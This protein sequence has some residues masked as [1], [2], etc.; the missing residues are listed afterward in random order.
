MGES[1]KSEKTIR[2]YLLGRVLDETRLEG[3]EELLFTDEDFCSQVALA[4]DELINDYVFGRLGDDD[5]E[6]FRATLAG[7]SERRFKLELT[8]AL[9]EKA[10]AR[11][12]KSTKERPP[13]FSSLIL[14]FRQPV[15]A[16]AFAVLLLAVVA[17]TLYFS[18][19]GNPDAMAEL[20]SVYQMARPTETRISEF[21]YAPLS[22][23]RG[24]PTHADANRLRRIENNLIEATEKNSNAD[25]HHA[26]GV[27][28]LT[29]RRY[30]IAIKEFE[31]ALKLG[32]NSART[33]NDLGVA[34]FE[35]S[36]TVAKEKKL[37]EVARSLE[38][39]TKA[40]GLDGNL[41]EALFNKA[42]ALESLGSPREAK[43]SWMLYLNKDSSSPWADEARKNLAGLE[44]EQTLFKSE[45][46]VLADFLT[47]YRNHDYARAQKIHN[48]TK[49]LL[50]SSA[51]PM[52]LSRR[53]LLARQRGNETEATES[54]EALTHVGN[55]ERTLNGDSFFFELANFY[56]RVR[57]NQVEPLL[58][59]HDLLAA[60]VEL[61][62]GFAKAIA[63]FEKSRDLFAQLGDLCDAAVAES[64][65]VQ[66]LLE[67]GRIAEG[68]ERLEAAI[69]NAER[70]KFKV[71]EPTAYY[72]FA[73]GAFG[74]DHLSESDKNLKIA[75]RLAESDHNA[76]EVQHAREA[77]ARGYSDL[78]ELGAALTYASTLL[79]DE[80]LYYVSKNQF[81]RDKA[82]LAVLALKLEFYATS[83]SLAREHLTVVQ[84]NWPPAS[85][86]VDDS[87]R[88]MV[89]AA[90]ANQDYADALKYANESMQIALTRGDSAENTRVTAE[91]HLLLAKIKSKT[92]D[93][94]GALAD[95]DRAFDLYRRLPELTLGSYEIHKGKL[96]CFQQLNEQ[97]NFAEEL[98]T[99]L[100]LSE[101]YRHNIREDDSRQAFFANEQDVFDAAIEH[102]IETQDSRSAFTFSEDSKARSLLDFVESDKSIAE[103]EKDFGAVSQPLTLA[104]IQDRLPD[105]VQFVQYAVLPHSLAIWIVTRTRFQ[106]LMKPIT[107]A[108]L[109]NRIAAYQSLIVLQQPA[110]DIRQAGQ[111]L[112]QLLIPPD[113]SS[114]KQLGLIPDKALHQLSFATLVAPNGKYLLEDYALFY[115]PSASVLVLATENA[116]RKERAG[117]E[118]LLSIGNPDFDREQNPNL[119]D[120][121]SAE[122]EAR[123]VAGHYQSSLE[124]I[125]DA[126][127]KEKFLLNFTDVDVVHFAG[128][129]LP[130]GQSPGNSKLLFAGGDLRS[131]ELSAYKLPKAKLVV[132]SACETGFERYNKSE[133]A[134]GIARTLLAM[135]APLVVASQWQVDSEPTKDLMI[136]FHRNRKEK[137]LTTGES[138]RQAQLEL[139]SKAE[140]KAPFY[141]A[142]F[143]LF[144]G[145][146]NY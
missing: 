28:Y 1:L 102:A 36:K 131:S 59:A 43:E 87:L 75:L 12:V 143:S 44:S 7:N 83:L 64:W 50:N 97:E 132:L 78:G 38:E 122:D 52:Q 130:N 139:L 26:L 77:L 117:S 134:I 137:G 4:E 15:Y 101:E 47:A 91:I 46:R 121:R 3:L 22:Q 98:K 2:E 145:Y 104:G 68:R 123:D 8:Q 118:S 40:T 116:Q 74:Q 144:G 10:L 54:I 61:K 124:L 85:S 65:A 120:L 45:E 109:E 128:H 107:A 60:A 49:G 113:L 13:F 100:A 34:H 110:A 80:G 33:H 84:I 105:Q 53:Y 96:L 70:R 19:R 141:W 88:L 57:A 92:N 63:D 89:R 129:F 21:G 5:A 30:A 108:E 103:V 67:I 136:A 135:G 111:E 55:F 17:L 42:L 72:W 119:P 126:A 82:T 9:R 73:M 31:I 37:V 11:N 25:S 76:F 20:R 62:G 6:S 39:F 29:Q 99:V 79:P 18:R 56:A 16:G 81:L 90:S 71:L 41:L 35:L 24:A 48:E 86:R 32:D 51:V 133:G 69:K 112:Y 14:F 127:T 95:Y 125:G 23:L 58:Q 146:A 93:F 138:L 66:V 106:L 27:F 114:E 142:A 140:T 94:R 115:A